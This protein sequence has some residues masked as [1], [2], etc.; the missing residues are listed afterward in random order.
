MSLSSIYK[1]IALTSPYM[2]ILL[3]R[4]YWSN[5]GILK[6]YNPNKAKAKSQS[7]EKSYVDFENVIDWLR[8]QGVGDIEQTSVSV[9]QREGCRGSDLGGQRS[10]DHRR[11]ERDMEHGT[12]SG[13]SRGGHSYKRRILRPAQW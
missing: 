4:I 2:E 5:A 10:R 9:K 6:K 12:A 11:T 1:R 8:K 7:Q 3:R 13:W